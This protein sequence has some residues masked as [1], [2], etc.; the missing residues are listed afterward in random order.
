MRLLIILLFSL[1]TVSA[2]NQD[3]N[4]ALKLAR[5]EQ[6]E[7][8]ERI[9][10]NLTG[11]EPANGDIYY[12]Y[13][14][15]IIKDYQADTFSNSLRDV[16]KNAEA[17]FRKGI[18]VDSTNALNFVGLGE[19]SLLRNSDTSKADQYFIKA[20]SSIPAKKKF[21]TPKHAVIL[22]EL[23]TS[24]L[25]G[26]INRYNKAI[27]YL[28]RAKE[29]DPTNSSI[30]IALGD[31]YIRQNDGTNA[32]AN[33]N[34]ALSI[35]PKSP[36]PKIKIGNIYMRVPN[37]TA[38]RP[39]FEEAREIDSTFAPV[40]RELGELYTMAGRY[41]LA[42]LNYRKFLELSGNNIPAKVQYGNSLF[43]SKD[44]AGALEII[45]EVLK[46]DESRNYLNRL[47][48]YCSY[49]KKP[50]ELE[51]GLKYIEQFFK[52]TDPESIIPRDYIYY[53][54]ILYKLAKN[55]SLILAEAF[56]KFNMAYK[57]DTTDVSLLSELALNYYYARWYKEASVLFT[58]KIEKGISN[59]DDLMFIGKSY[60]QL[61][62]FNKADSFFTM[63]TVNQPENLQAYLY[64]ARTYSSMDPGS[65]KGLAKTKFELLIE[66]I[67][68]E[69][70]K[71][72][73][74][75][76]EAYSYMGSYYLFQKKDY[77]EAKSWF[78]K[79]YNLDPNNKQW[80]I[81]SLRSQALISYKQKNY[82][83]ARD[84]YI[85]IKELDPNDPDAAQ[86]IKDL[87]KA[88]TANQKPQ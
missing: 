79:L 71:Y 3:L 88:I 25:L 26:R 19:V 53:G 7:E 27:N 83:E 85:K 46:V 28:N 15:T 64:I 67:G 43:K 52:N 60:Y 80:Q 11:S 2:F 58:K 6:F 74:E 29:I 78:I 84:L 38:A 82:T 32:L 62:E 16:V 23:G 87:N 41:D 47:A 12:Y 77:N 63:V 24:Q 21:L 5:S 14:K 39:Y 44:Y 40:Y 70:D 22:T 20:E 31:V 18:Q 10:K 76:Q 9:F 54:R 61:K 34:K 17:L 45:E 37:L 35:D 8:A 50:P 65:E 68:S 49:D 66:K 33:Y 59:S 75:L 4:T 81:Q 42:K 56:D 73:K 30:F 36:L 13:G 51:K 55:D 86:A 57:M 72:A 48:A 69:T 1:I